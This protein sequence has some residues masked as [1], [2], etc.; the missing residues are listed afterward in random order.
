MAVAGVG[1]LGYTSRHVQKIEAFKRMTPQPS[2]EQQIVGCH[3]SDFLSDRRQRIVTEWM[4]AVRLDPAVPAADEL[5]L[6][7]LQDH[8]P[9]ILDDLNRSLSEALGPEIKERSA[10]RAATHAQLRWE[11]HYDISQLIREIADLRRVL[12]YH[13]A[14]FHDDRAPSFNG[15]LGVFAM[16]VVHSFCDRIIRIAVEQFLATSRT[17]QRPK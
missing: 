6:V 14:E 7:Q 1:V 12:I 15:R 10:W 16:V 17:V 11:Q 8:V 5:S 3:L 4:E 13:L 2:P 9:Q